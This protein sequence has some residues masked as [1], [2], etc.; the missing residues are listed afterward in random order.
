M[1]SGDFAMLMAGAPHIFDDFHHLRVVRLAGHAEA[2][3]Q[4]THPNI[5]RIHAVRRGDRV[6]DPSLIRQFQSG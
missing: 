5:K 3:A 4:V 1:N 2:N 6:D